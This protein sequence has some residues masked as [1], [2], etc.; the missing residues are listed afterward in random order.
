MTVTKKAG[1][2]IDHRRAVILILDPSG[3]HSSVIAS[4]AHKHLERS[5]DSP[6]KGSYE[7]AQVPA[8]DRRQRAF[9]GEL[10]HYYDAVIA[11]IRDSAEMFLCGPGEAKGELHRRLEKFNLADRVREV[12]TVD[13]LTDAQV[14]AKVREHF[15]VPWHAKA[16]RV[17]RPNAGH[18]EPAAKE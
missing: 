14:A 12:Q 16:P 11:V 8:D 7:A 4:D 13:K 3:E 2:W 1:V 17:G 18:D 10:N 6:L 9:T 5:G 15:S